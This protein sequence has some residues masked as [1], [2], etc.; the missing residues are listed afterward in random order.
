M[1]R[2]FVCR[3]RAAAIVVGFALPTLV[4]AQGGPRAAPSV[5][6]LPVFELRSPVPSETLAIVLSG[7]GGWADIDREVGRTLSARGVDVVGFDDRAYL[8][9]GHRSPDGTASDVAR[10]AEHYMQEWSDHRLVL[11]GYSRGAD[12]AP[13]VATRLPAGLRQRLAL[14]AMLGLSEH[15]GF[16]FHFSDLWSS[17]SD[18][19]D[20]AILPE[21]QRLR[22]TNMMCVYGTKE[23]ESLC[24]TV[25]STLVFRD[26]RAGGHH[27]DGDYRAIADLILARVNAPTR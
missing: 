14:V 23:D 21:L 19:H 27:F 7:D 26:A 2:S 24:R 6:D 5:G 1:I 18:P 10:V 9:S 8:K 3:T 17:H 15:A 4:G 16:K 20:P 12:F 25:D 13:F 22:G 11:V